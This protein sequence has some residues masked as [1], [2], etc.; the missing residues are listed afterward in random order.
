MEE[1]SGSGRL[2]MIMMMMLSEVMSGISWQSRR[3]VLRMSNADGVTSHRQVPRQ[4]FGRRFFRVRVQT[5]RLIRLQMRPF[6][7]VTSGQQNQCISS[8]EKKEKTFWG[9]SEMSSR[10][11][12]AITSCHVCT[13]SRDLHGNGDDGN[14]GFP[15]GWKLMS[16]G[17]HG[18]GSKCCGSPTGMEI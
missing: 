6:T 13:I 15:R 4:C 12:T 10:K 2:M 17:S 8:T 5:Y 9:R 18:N 7:T 3:L 1:W 14:P 11:K 16:R